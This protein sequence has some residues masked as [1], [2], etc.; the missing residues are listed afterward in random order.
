M[1]PLYFSLIS[2]FVLPIRLYVAHMLV[3]D[4]GFT[5]SGISMYGSV[6]R[7]K[8]WT[9]PS[10][11]PTVLSVYVC[12]AVCVCYCPCMCVCVLVHQHLCVVMTVMICQQ[13]TYTPKKTFYL[14]LQLL[15]P[16]RLFLH[17]SH[18]PSCKH[19]TSSCLLIQIFLLLSLIYTF[20][21]LI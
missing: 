2:I 4:N 14:Q 5:G 6:Q 17:S 13:M 12:E 15:F 7:C 16:S 20:S 10:G 3:T 21:G 8:L 1:L 9:L 11:A 18:Q 19:N